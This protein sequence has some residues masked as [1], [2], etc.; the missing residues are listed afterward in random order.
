METR[1]TLVQHRTTVPV[2]IPSFSLTSLQ[3][4]AP[5]IPLFF[6]SPYPLLLF[7]QEV[8]LLPSALK[9]GIVPKVPTLVLL[10]YLLQILTSP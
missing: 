4:A 7:Q 5:Q 6:Q 1:G 10:S 2:S 8:P 3:H 9:E